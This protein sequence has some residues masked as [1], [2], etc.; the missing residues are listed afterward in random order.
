MKGKKF[1]VFL[2]LMLIVSMMLPATLADAA[3]TTAKATAVDGRT[4][5]A[6]QAG[7][8]SDWIEIARNGDYV[9]LVRRDVLPCSQIYFSAKS[10]QNSYNNSKARDFVNCWFNYDLSSSARLRNYTVTNSATSNLGN[11][12]DLN[13]G[14]SQPNSNSAKTGNDVAFLLS[15]SEAALYCSQYYAKNT[16]TVTASSAIARAN[17]CKLRNPSSGY[18]YNTW[19]LRSPAGTECGCAQISSV[20]GHNKQ[21]PD[22]SVY[23]CFV[24]SCYPFIRPA[25]WVKSTIFEAEKGCVIVKHLDADTRLEVASTQTYTVAPGNYGPYGPLTIANYGPGT[26]APGSAPTSGTINSN[27]TITITYLYSKAKATITIRHIDAETKA[28]LTTPLVFSVPIGSYG[29]YYA[30]SFANYQAG[31]LSVGSAPASGTI[32]AG[33]SITIIYE[34][35]KSGALI[36][37]RHINADTGDNLVAPVTLSVTPGYYGPYN[38]ISLSNYQPGTLAAGSA[39]ASGYISAGQSITITYEYRLTLGMVIVWHKNATTYE[40]IVPYE[41]YVLGVGPYGPYGPATVP[42]YTSSLASFSAS[43]S[44]ILNPGQ[45]V[46]ITYLY[47]QLNWSTIVV[48]YREEGTNRL[49]LP[50]SVYTVAPG[51]YGPYYPPALNGFYPASLD[52][53]SAPI[54]GIINNGQ[55]I[56]IIYRYR[57]ITQEMIWP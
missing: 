40:N 23:R 7:D 3:T 13:A 30:Q 2:T 36:T 19:Y 24:Q 11:F 38:P 17:N 47:T 53:S 34:Y 21:T 56:T 5:T 27:Q 31:T 28:D 51:T 22:G 54:T 9:L 44:G 32:T 25:V 55:T 50:S 26:L 18:Q 46:E 15:F 6:A 33:Q 43:P 49:L 8:T 29:P 16:C 20:G 4:L 37:L 1:G 57:P 39:A 10:N 35:R 52:P 45:V 14:H 41:F 48:E 12:A 42:G